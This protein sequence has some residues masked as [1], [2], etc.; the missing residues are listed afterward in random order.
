MLLKNWKMRIWF[1]AR[2][3][4]PITQ[5]WIFVT[6]PS[7]SHPFVGE[8]GTPPPVAALLYPQSAQSEVWFAIDKLASIAARLSRRTG[9]QAP[10]FAPRGWLSCS[11]PLARISPVK[12]WSCG[13]FYCIFLV[14]SSGIFHRGRRWPLSSHL[15]TQWASKPLYCRWLLMAIGLVAFGWW[16]ERS[17]FFSLSSLVFEEETGLC[18]SRDCPR[19][20]SCLGIFFC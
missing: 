17:S 10:T 3:L 19:R 18:G 2:P 16:W 12:G 9:C 4:C 1:I 7:L 11:S 6:P 14:L 20:F 15:K 5:R 13:G 8:G